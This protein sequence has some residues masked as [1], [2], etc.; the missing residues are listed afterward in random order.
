MNVTN[1][2]C[3]GTECKD[4]QARQA[5]VIA[6]HRHKHTNTHTHTPHHQSDSVAARIRYNAT[7]PASLPHGLYLPEDGYSGQGLK[8]KLL[9]TCVLYTIKYTPNTCHNQP[10]DVVM[11]SMNVM[12][13]LDVTGVCCTVA[14]QSS[15]CF[16]QSDC[17]NNPPSI[18]LCCCCCA[19]SCGTFC[20]RSSESPS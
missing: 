3:E 10:L 11:K 16:L 8:G 12:Q 2:H 19:V 4:F 20:V 17:D 14:A 7:H 13:F 6:G 5:H 9:Q 15:I 1:R 18:S